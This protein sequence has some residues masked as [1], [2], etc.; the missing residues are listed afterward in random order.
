MTPQNLPFFEV[1]DTCTGLSVIDIIIWIINIFNNFILIVIKKLFFFSL[2]A[3]YLKE[4]KSKLSNKSS[5][6][7][8]YIFVLDLAQRRHFSSKGHPELPA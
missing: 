3:S 6:R 5:Y 1:S 8:K 4:F 7:G 2:E